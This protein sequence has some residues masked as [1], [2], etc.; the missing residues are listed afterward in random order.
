MTP[1]ETEQK[2]PA[3]VEGLLWGRGLTGTHHRDGDTGNNSLGSF[4][5]VQTLLEFSINLTKEPIDP[6]AG[7]PQAK[8]LPGREHNP[9]HQQ[10]IRLRFY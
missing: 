1:Q 10:I 3:L 7:S 5:L 2:L 4:L 6:R 9:T 8:K